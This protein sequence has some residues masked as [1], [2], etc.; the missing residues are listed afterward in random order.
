MG[1]DG[2]YVTRECI[3]FGRTADEYR[4]YIRLISNAWKF[5]KVTQNVYAYQ[6]HGKGVSPQPDETNINDKRKRTSNS[7]EDF[8]HEFV[9][10]AADA[11]RRGNFGAIIIRHLAQLNYKEK[12]NEFQ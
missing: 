7:I 11:W 6:Q 8:M 12:N 3:G 10:P 5:P 4:S 9:L 1:P 2:D